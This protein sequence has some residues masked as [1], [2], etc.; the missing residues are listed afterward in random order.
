MEPPAT[1]YRQDSKGG[2]FQDV[3]ETPAMPAA[4]P[5]LQD[6]PQGQGRSGGTC[7]WYLAKS[8][9][10]GGEEPLKQGHLLRSEVLILLS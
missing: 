6:V 2:W 1:Q 4:H 8:H 5:S 3:Q 10:P 7:S 9:F